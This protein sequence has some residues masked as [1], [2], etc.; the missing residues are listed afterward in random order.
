MRFVLSVYERIQF[1]CMHVLI[2]FT[3]H[4]KISIR[5]II[6]GNE[7]TPKDKEGLMYCVYELTIRC[8]FYPF[9]LKKNNLKL[10]LLIDKITLH[11]N[12]IP[13]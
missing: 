10:H 3:E 1:M 11:F 6:H 2:R 8:H 13:F 9:Y 5:M 7:V 12:P 4:C